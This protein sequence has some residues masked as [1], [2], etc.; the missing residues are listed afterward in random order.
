VKEAKE[1]AMMTVTAADPGYDQAR[2]VW[3]ERFD[4]RPRAVL[5]PA[6]AAEVAAA[7]GGARD[8][9]LPFRIRSGGHNVEGF[10]VLDDGYVID[11]SRL[12]GATVSADRTR[13]TVAA[14][15]LLGDVYSQ[16]WAAG[17]TIPAGVCPDIRIGGH[18]LG[19]GV[20]MLVRSR[21]M[22]IDS[23]AGLTMVDADGRVLEADDDTH[24]DL[25]WACRGGG[26]G[27]FGVVTSYTFRTRP[28]GD[29]TM[30]TGSWDFPDAIA[31]LDRWQHWIVGV[32]QRVNA[33]F[34][35][36][37][38]AVGGGLMA[39]LFEGTP[40]EWASLAGPLL[41]GCPP[42]GYEV[43]QTAYID[44]VG[45]YSQRVPSIRA[46]FVPALAAGPVEDEA[47]KILQRRHRDAPAGVKTGFY[48]LGG[49]VL[50]E[51]RDRSAFAHRDSLFCVEYLGHWHGAEND[52][53][54][55]GW[56]AG[57]RDELR[58]FMTGGAY[59]NSPDRD[60]T[61]WLHAYYGASLPRLMEVKRRYDPQDV[62]RFEQ[63]I[64]VRLSPSAARAAGLTEPVIADL[65]ARGLLD[66]DQIR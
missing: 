26:G 56:L 23:L 30:V 33:R 4:R 14:G 45:A 64:P 60:L 19:G 42:A 61:D 15:T 47:L 18:V 37:P 7:I 44:S 65:S 34:S 25:M 8:E 5:Y 62:F 10:S 46:K 31:A 55:L 39:A 29:V 21:G 40:A 24:P 22:L 51:S 3:N 11:L 43:R 2:T 36:F 13:A 49:A 9:G 54:H 53:E 16:L 1:H 20:G 12:T 6:D 32:D 41:R 58:P 52:A 27:N 28:I 38:P 59:V 57:T 63:S 66:P 35:L 50:S 17:V 48:G